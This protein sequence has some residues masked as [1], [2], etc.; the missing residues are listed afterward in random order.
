MTYLKNFGKANLATALR[1]YVLPSDA[2]PDAAM[3]QVWFEVFGEDPELDFDQTVDLVIVLAH[4][5]GDPNDNL[6][7]RS[8]TRIQKLLSEFLDDEQTT[9]VLANYRAWAKDH[10]YSD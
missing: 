2:D 5:Y 1:L 9:A 6:D 8:L 10:K 7:A 3:E 4:T